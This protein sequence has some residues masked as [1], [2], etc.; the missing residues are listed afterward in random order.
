[1]K[2]DGVSNAKGRLIYVMFG[3]ANDIK[4]RFSISYDYPINFVI[5]DYAKYICLVK[6]KLCLSNRYLLLY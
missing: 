4:N 1:V 2:Y 6:S 3:R 5:V